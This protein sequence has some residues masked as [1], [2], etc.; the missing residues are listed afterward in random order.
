MVEVYF[1]DFCRG[2]A[3][4]LH[5]RLSEYHEKKMKF[6]RFVFYSIFYI[7]LNLLM[8]L[9]VEY[10]IINFTKTISELFKDNYHYCF[11]NK[12]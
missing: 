8:M 1:A 12:I 10:Y 3:G 4:P 2:S 5:G 11:F 7:I 6:S 9:S